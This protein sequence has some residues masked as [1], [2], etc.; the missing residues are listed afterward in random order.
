MNRALATIA[1]ISRGSTRF[2]AAGRSPGV[3]FM[4]GLD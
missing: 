4:G 3:S 1:A 2:G